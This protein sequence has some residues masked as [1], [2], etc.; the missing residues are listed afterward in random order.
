M[1]RVSSTSASSSKGF[2][3]TNTSVTTKTT[4]MGGAALAISEDI[5]SEQ[6]CTDFRISDLPI[7]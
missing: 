3:P 1:N 4:K 6:G 7:F 2:N 5:L